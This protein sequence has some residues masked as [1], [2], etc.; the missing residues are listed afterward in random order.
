M[1]VAQILHARRLMAA[2]ILESCWAF[3]VL[4][5]YNPFLVRPRR[6]WRHRRESDRAPPAG[7]RVQGRG[8]LTGN[9]S[10]RR[11]HRLHQ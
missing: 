6:P 1:I 8:L 3:L 11:P 4:S 10:L 2:A 7:L 5:F 9:L